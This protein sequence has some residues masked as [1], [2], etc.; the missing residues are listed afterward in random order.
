MIVLSRYFPIS[1]VAI[2]ICL[3]VH[4]NDPTHF[5]FDGEVARTYPFTHELPDSLYFHLIPTS[6][7]NAGWKIIINKEPAPIDPSSN[8]GGDNFADIN[9]PLH[10]PNTT[11]I[12]GG[13]FKDGKSTNFA[14]DHKFEFALSRD[15]DKS[16]WTEYNCAIQAQQQQSVRG[17][18][19]ACKNQPLFPK[20]LGYATLHIT[21]HQLSG[22]FKA[23]YSP[24]QT[25]NIEHMKFTVSGDYE[26]PRAI[27]K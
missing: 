1:L 21:D 22:S 5:Q 17:Q 14:V 2:L 25:L 7:L 20:R 13:Y 16:V 8:R 12:N 23:G 11:D 26:A 4:A 10:G 3:P 9:P 6:P 27:D 15:D 18:K 19:D 24:D